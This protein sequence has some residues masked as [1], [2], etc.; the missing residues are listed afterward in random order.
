MLVVWRGCSSALACCSS[1]HQTQAGG[2]THTLYAHGYAAAACPAFLQVLQAT[3]GAASEAGSLTVLRDTD[4]L[5]RPH[6][7]DTYGLKEGQRL[8]L[9]IGVSLGRGGSLS[10]GQLGKVCARDKVVIGKIEPGLM[11]TG[12]HLLREGAGGSTGDCCHEKCVV[13]WRV[14]DTRGACGGSRRSKVAQGKGGC[15]SARVAAPEGLLL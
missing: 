13:C 2:H 5:G 11:M 4:A 9:K 1:A 7:L 14:S 3:V 6:S 15:W 8:L 10:W 12:A